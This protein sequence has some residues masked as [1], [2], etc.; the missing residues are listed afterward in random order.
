V[1]LRG[2]FF[3]EMSAELRSATHLRWNLKGDPLIPAAIIGGSEEGSVFDVVIERYTALCQ[4]AED[5]LVRLVTVEVEN[6]LK[7]HLTR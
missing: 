1:S 4:R 3:V 5:M 7:Q 2:K 6:D